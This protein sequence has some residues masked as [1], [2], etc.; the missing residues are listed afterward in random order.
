MTEQSFGPEKPANGFHLS[1]DK[2]KRDN[3]LKTWQGE[4]AQQVCMLLAIL[5]VL[6]TIVL[7]VKL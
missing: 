7:L 5:G 2:P 6:A 1:T 4:V 3:G